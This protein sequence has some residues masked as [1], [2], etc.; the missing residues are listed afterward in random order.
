MRGNGV[1]IAGLS[2]PGALFSCLRLD[3][4]AQKADK[5]HSM[6]SPLCL[7]SIH[8]Q[9]SSKTPA[10]KP[11][12]LVRACFPSPA[13]RAEG[14][15]HQRQLCQQDDAHANPA[16][17]T[18]SPH[19]LPSNRISVASFPITSESRVT[20]KLVPFRGMHSEARTYF[21]FC[22]IPIFRI[23]SIN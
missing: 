10:V 16:P 22:A 15:E 23:L 12:S 7:I 4:L 19:T 9:A 20:A 11:T 3:F 13:R 1:C 17:A 18:C 8:S 5:C 2:L 14:K 21:C 6:F